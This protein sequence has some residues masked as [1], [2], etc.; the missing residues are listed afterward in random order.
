MA[1]HPNPI[2]RKY[3]LNASNWPVAYDMSNEEFDQLVA[4]ANALRAS[5]IALDTTIAANRVLLDA[6]I[7]DGD[8]H[9]LHGIK[10]NHLIVLGPSLSAQV[11]LTADAIAMDDDETLVETWNATG[12]IGVSGAGGLDYALPVTASTWHSIWAIYN[13]T[14]SAKALLL[15]TSAT[16]PTLPSG[17]TGKRKLGWIYV[18]VTSIISPFIHIPTT[19]LFRIFWRDATE[20]N[21]FRTSLAAGAGVWNTEDFSSMLPTGVRGVEAVIH[22]AGGAGQEIHGR[23]VGASSTGNY[24]NILADYSYNLYET[25]VPLVLDASQ[26]FDFMRALA[27]GP[28]Y[29]YIAGIYAEDE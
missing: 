2:R 28:P 8:L 19:D 10:H 24:A 26:R 9:A 14:T 11:T 27:A 21:L 23:P 13:P 18:G 20:E 4:Q 1:T 22:A 17:Y 25:G 29:V 5:G 12:D 16:T 15:S 7:A 3:S 6:H